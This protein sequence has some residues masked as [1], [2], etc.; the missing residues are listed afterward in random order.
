MPFSKKENL[1]NLVIETQ[2]FLLLIKTQNLLD[3]IITK[4]FQF[5]LKEHENLLI[6]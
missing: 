2:V 1:L 4:N 6:I 3:L 5:F